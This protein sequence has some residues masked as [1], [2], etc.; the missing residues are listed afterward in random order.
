ME[1]IE[2]GHSTG[3]VSNYLNYK[4]ILTRSLEKSAK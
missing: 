2:Y 3:I 1:R 4:H